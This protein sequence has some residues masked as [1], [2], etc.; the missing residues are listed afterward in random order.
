[1]PATY[2]QTGPATSGAMGD[3]NRDGSP[4]FV[5]VGVIYNS[6]SVMLNT[7]SI[8]CPSPSFGPATY[9]SVGTQPQSVAV[10]DFNRDGKSDL[11]VANYMSN[12][13]SVLLGDGNGAFGTAT[14]FPVGI[15]PLSV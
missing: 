6:A 15:Q 14:T 5:T 7:C 10:S 4:D 9:F 12:N 3:F 2:F 1:G 8:S 13:L 11:A